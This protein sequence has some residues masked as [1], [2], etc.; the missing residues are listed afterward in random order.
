[1][2]ALLR[3]TS[4]NEILKNSSQIVMTRHLQEFKFTAILE[5]KLKIST[6]INF[7][8]HFKGHK[9]SVLI[10]WQGW[11][12]SWRKWFTRMPAAPSIPM[13]GLRVLQ[14]SSAVLC[15]LLHHTR[16]GS[17]IEAMALL[18]KRLYQ[19]LGEVTEIWA[20]IFLIEATCHWPIT[21]TEPALT[22]GFK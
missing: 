12:W 1:M 9:F 14:G 2:T 8:R 7:T 21:G 20:K 13:G 4:N 15:R 18:R 11:S 5:L 6:K 10:H 22:K 3:N 17:Q 16:S 19:H